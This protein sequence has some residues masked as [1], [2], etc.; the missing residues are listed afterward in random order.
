M[1]NPQAGLKVLEIC[2]RTGGFC[3]E[4][5]DCQPFKERHWK[6]GVETCPHRDTREIRMPKCDKGVF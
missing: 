3:T 6:T 5:L 2:N 4:T 1:Y